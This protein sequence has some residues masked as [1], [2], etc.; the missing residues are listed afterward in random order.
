MAHWFLSFLIPFPSFLNDCDDQVWPG[1]RPV[2]VRG[3]V[4]QGS[5][6]AANRKLIRWWSC[7]PLEVTC[8]V[9]HC[10]DSLLFTL[11]PF[12]YVTKQILSI[13]SFNDISTQGRLLIMIEY[14]IQIC[15]SLSSD[16]YIMYNNC[17]RVDTRLWDFSQNG[18]V[19]PWRLSGVS[20]I[21]ISVYIYISHRSIWWV[22]SQV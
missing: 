17:S 19:S 21:R 18:L 10:P 3:A 15:F 11:T 20:V 9:E 1:G 13:S 5:Q 16:R 7:L 8:R 2:V 6:G 14:I 12:Y 22:T 4:L